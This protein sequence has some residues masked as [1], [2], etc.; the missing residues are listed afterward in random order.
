MKKTHFVLLGFVTLFVL[1]FVF[2]NQ[3]KVQSL[4]VIKTSPPSGGRQNPYAPISIFFNRAPKENEVVFSIQPQT[5]V[6]ISTGS[7][8]GIIIT[9]KTTLVPSTTYLVKINTVPEYIL[10]F[11]TEQIESNTPGWNDLFNAAQQQYIQSHGTQ[12]EA[13]KS[14]RTESPIQQLGFRIEYTYKS[15]T[16]VVFLSAPHETNKSAFLSW[17]KQRGVTDLTL[18]RITYIN[19]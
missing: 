5:E 3:T 7:Q 8:S 6:E 15:N 13:L 1:V 4:A 9:P 2:I 11:E 16:Y 17:M 14:I 12:D 10:K 19:Q 18:L